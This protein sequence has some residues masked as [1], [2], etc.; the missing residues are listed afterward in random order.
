MTKSKPKG[1]KGNNLPM[2]NEGKTSKVASVDYNHIN[3]DNWVKHEHNDYIQEV[4]VEGKVLR[5]G[6]QDNWGDGM[7]KGSK[8]DVKHPIG[9]RGEGAKR[10]TPMKSKQVKKDIRK[11]FKRGKKNSPFKDG[12]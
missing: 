4:R 2:D 9:W 8:E 6:K 5:P 11:Q 10:A 1:P 3:A 7:S 12:R